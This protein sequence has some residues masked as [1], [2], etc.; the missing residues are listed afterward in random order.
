MRCE[1]GGFSSLQM[2]KLGRREAEQR[3]DLGTPAPGCF[4]RVLWRNRTVRFQ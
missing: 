1:L 3:G 4:T 2:S